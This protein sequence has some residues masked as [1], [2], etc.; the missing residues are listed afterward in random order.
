MEGEFIAY[1]RVS[2]DKQGRSGLGLEA[3]RQAVLDYLNGGGWE[4]LAEF[5]E[6]ESGSKN[7]RPKLKE[8]LNLCKRH[9][10]KLVIARLDR[11]SRNAAFLLALRDSKVDFIAVDLPQADAFTVGILALVAE[12][13]AQMISARTKAALKAAKARGTKLGN[14]T[15]LKEAGKAGVQTTKAKATQASANVLPIIHQIKAAGVRSLQGIADAL[16]AR[17]VTTSRG[18]AWY[19]ESVRRAI[20][21]AS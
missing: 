12:R 14:P 13:E 8:A 9:K 1:Y 5:T 10:A 19:P 17:G 4:L 15:N 18:S 20:L 21:R 3:Q 16:N 7:Q 11:L 2:T 6:V